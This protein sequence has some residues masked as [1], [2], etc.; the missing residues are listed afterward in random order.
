MIYD[1]VLTI[2]VIACTLVILVI[3]LQTGRGAGLTVFG[4]GGDSLITTP[5]GSS[6]MRKLTGVLAGS[7]AVTSL[8]LALLSGRTGMSSVTS[9]VPLP[10]AAP[11]QAPTAPA[12]QAPQA[13]TP[14]QAPQGQSQQ[15]R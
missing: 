8:F 13:A 6:F 3:L 1:F 10:M 12:Q 14:G 15:S 7:F 4:G 5:T 11:Q 2:H 9:K